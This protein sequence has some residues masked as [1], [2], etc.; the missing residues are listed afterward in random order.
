M[1][2]QIIALLTPKGR[3]QMVRAV[4]NGGLTEAAAARQSTKEAINELRKVQG[5]W[6]LIHPYLNRR[7]RGLWAAAEA[8]VCGHG[9]SRLVAR[10]TGLA[11]GTIRARARELRLTKV[12][13]LKAVTKEAHR[14]GRPLCEMRD[15]G[16]EAALER[17]LSD[18]T[19]GN[20]MKNQKWVRT[21]LRQLSKSLKTQGYQACH[22][23]V[24]RLLRKLG[25]SLKVCRRT[26]IGAQHP[27]RDKQFQYI[28]ELK[29]AFLAASFPVIS[30]DT[31]K[32]ELIGNFKREG[33]TWCKTPI[34]V[35]SY[36]ASYAQCIALPF[37]IYDIA[38][39]SGYV[40]VGISH[41]TA[42]FA[43][44]CIA[45][46]WSSFG[47]SL[48]PRA[49]RV[50]ILADGGGCNG[51]N[52]RSWKM[53]LQEKICDNF[54]LNV[55]V[56]HYPPGCSKWNPIEYR[57]FSPISINWAGRPLCDLDSMLAFIRGTTTE[58]GLKVEACLD[59]QVYRK[60]RQVNDRQLEKLSLYAHEVCPTWNY[61]LMPRTNR[62]LST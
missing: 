54:G 5:R 22:H 14:P 36:F 52:L 29:K 12:G 57:L 13:I 55:T 17:L 27:D 50:L 20:P 6:D 46:W 8:E 31:K 40:T 59:Q 48:Y 19:A 44:N 15:N 30:I 25:Y 61:T 62:Q 49:D 33:K 16:I 56:S 58:G 53:D 37:G 9:G 41:N 51:H 47:R 45:K 28:A 23:T 10:V 2:T 26:Q 3:Q 35:E 42:E 24:A 7:Q 18:E 1:D 43:V 60:G 34:E 11:P 21:S 38:Q 32:K 4:L 39:N